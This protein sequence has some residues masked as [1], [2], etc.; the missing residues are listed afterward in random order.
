[1]SALNLLNLEGNY[2]YFYPKI[3]EFRKKPKFRSKFFQE[4]RKFSN[5]SSIMGNNKSRSRNTRSSITT[6][7][8]FMIPGRKKKFLNFLAENKKKILHMKFSQKRIIC[9]LRKSFQVEKLFFLKKIKKYFIYRHSSSKISRI[10]RG[11]CLNIK[12]KKKKFE[13]LFRL[14]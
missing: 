4:K 6:I 10:P 7:C 3:Q 8:F 9:C 12:K 11:R 2:F 1:M 14:N 13:I 5:F